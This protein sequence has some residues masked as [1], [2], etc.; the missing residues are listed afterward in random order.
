M[1]DDHRRDDT[2][3]DR[4]RRHPADVHVAA[5]VDRL[6]GVLCVEAFE[7]TEASYHR[8]IGW[9]RSP[10]HVERVGV[11]GTGSYGAGL[12]RQLDRAGITVVEVDR[13]NRQVRA[14]E[15]KSDPVDAVTAARAA[16]SGRALG[17]PKSRV[18]DVE[19]AS[20]GPRTTTT[21]LSSM[22]VATCSP[23]PGLATIQP[24]SRRLLTGSAHTGC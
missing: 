6:G 15:G 11:E 23:S 22:S 2:P 10:G 7:T 20:T 8:L 16:L 21:T 9:L 17:V 3:G 18:G 19:A 13:P 14:R 5:V 12:T 4:G 1:D 24:A